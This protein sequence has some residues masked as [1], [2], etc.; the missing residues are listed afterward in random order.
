MKGTTNNIRSGSSEEV[1]NIALFLASDESTFV[2]A[3]TI[4]VD[5]GWTAY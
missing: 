1:A 2:N 3:T 4:T 5:G